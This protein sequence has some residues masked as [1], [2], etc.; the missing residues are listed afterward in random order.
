MLG[1]ALASETSWKLTT[2]ALIAVGAGGI[3]ILLSVS[4]ASI[5]IYA[6]ACLVIICSYWF[7]T[8]SKRSGIAAAAILIMCIAGGIVVGPKIAERFKDGDYLG[9]SDLRTALN[10]M[11]RAMHKDSPVTGIGWNNNGIVNSRPCPKYSTILEEFNKMHRGYDEADPRHYR[12]N[13]LPESV[14]WLTLGET[15]YL[16]LAGL[17]SLFTISYIIIIRA[18][19]A[20]PNSSPWQW[21]FISIALIMTLTYAHS[22]I[23]RILICVPPV[24]T[25]WLIYI[26][27]ALARQLLPCGTKEFR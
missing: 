24:T 16:G 11:S 3:S 25:L 27:A 18:A 17:L 1:V 5:V 7:V 19:F 23:E 4:R 6:F 10:T 22:F 2:L 9:D 26:A 14:W 13:P 12:R 15:G 8:R 20:H 21:F